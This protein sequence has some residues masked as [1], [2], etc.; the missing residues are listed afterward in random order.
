MKQLQLICVGYAGSVAANFNMLS[1]YF[2]ETIDF[3]TVEYRG[4]GSRSKESKYVDNNDM[5]QD[6]AEQVKGLRNREIPYAILGYS[7]GAQV[8]YELFAQGL[9]TEPPTCTF[10]AAHEPPDVDCFGK[11]ID[12]EDEQGFLKQLRVYGGLDERLLKD[13]RFAAI[14]GARMKDDFKL[15]HEY[16]F[17][18]EYHK[19]LSKTV[20]IYCEQD[21]PYEKVQGW[22]Q[23]AEDIMFYEL[24]ENH[25]F[26]KS[27]PEEFCSIISKEI[28]N[29]GR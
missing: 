26:F 8:V 28:K 5:V 23:F 11:S 21:T 22:K 19:M 29:Q 12:L 16:R 24:G 27:H 25:F 4:R 7:M 3:V 2:D 1:P 15:L 10:L 13:A 18:G 9:L 20:M 6:V 17:N 14:Y